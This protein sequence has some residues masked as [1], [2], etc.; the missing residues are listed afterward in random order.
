MQNWTHILPYGSDSYSFWF[1][2][3]YKIVSY[4]DGEYHAFYMPEHFDN[5]GDY[6]SA[7]PS[8][9]KN[10]LCWESLEDAQRA[11]EMHAKNHQP[12]AKTIARA[13]SIVSGYERKA[14]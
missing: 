11:C 2:G 14:A 6:V 4:E 13:A 8:R 10:G 7:P 5:W 1:N 3:I 9:N 12:K